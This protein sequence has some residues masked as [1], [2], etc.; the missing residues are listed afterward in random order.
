MSHALRRRHSAALISLLTAL[1]MALAVAAPVSADSPGNNGTVK[2]HD[3]A[4]EP[5]PIIQ[6]EPHVGCG[7]HLHFFFADA[8]QAGDWW[9]QSWPPT[10]NGTTVLTGTYLTD[11]NG[12]YRDPAV[13]S[14]S[15]PAGHYKLFWVG[16]NDSNVKHKTFWT[17]DCPPPSECTWFFRSAAI[18]TEFNEGDTHLGGTFT[19][20]ENDNIMFVRLEANGSIVGRFP[21]GFLLGDMATITF[22]GP[23][24][25]QQILWHDNDPN[26]G[27]AGWSFNGIAGPLTGDGN[28]IT[29]TVDLTTST[30]NIDAGGDSG[31]IDFC[32]VPADS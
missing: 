13:G 7:F 2:I 12:E 23:I 8:G 29:Q 30:V 16:R 19:T 4:D 1:I 10:G 9:I 31:G 5:A 6:N 14:H 20:I 22:A 15:L 28:S 18:G 27:E 21:M 25:V 3:G 11:A 26:P 24:N 32:F 17:G